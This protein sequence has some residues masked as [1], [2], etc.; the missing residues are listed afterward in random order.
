MN[1]EV[2][3]LVNIELRKKEIKLKQLKYEAS[4]LEGEIK[5]L[6]EGIND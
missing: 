4:R 5:K 1:K 3:K 2:E 6:K